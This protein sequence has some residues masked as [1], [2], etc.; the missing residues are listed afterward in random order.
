MSSEEQA[1]AANSEGFQIIVDT[2]E[3]PVHDAHVTWEQV[4]EFA[5]PGQSQDP[6]YVFKVQFADAESEPHAGTL[7]KD[8]HVE[9]KRSGTIFSVLRSVVS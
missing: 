2:V 3:H 1:S 9:V 5:Y 7:V 6:Q 8:G 4:V